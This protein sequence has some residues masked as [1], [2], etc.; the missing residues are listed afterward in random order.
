MDCFIVAVIDKKLDNQIHTLILSKD[1][2]ANLLMN[3]DN[4]KYG[5]GDII[6]T[7]SEKSDSILQ[8]CKQ[9]DNLETGEKE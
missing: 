1:E 4:E 8:F 9:Y 2:L 7:H 6:N 5:I 3:V